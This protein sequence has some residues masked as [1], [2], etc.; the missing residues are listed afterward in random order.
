MRKFKGNNTGN[1]YTEIYSDERGSL[2]EQNDYRVWHNTKWVRDCLTE[3]KEPVKITVWKNVWQ[4]RDGSYLLGCDWYDEESAKR[5]AC[6]VIGAIKYIK[7]VKF[8]MEVV[9]NVT[10]TEQ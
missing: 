8:E 1:I 2:L 3:I 10:E 5:D 4:R 9:T 6:E 7:T